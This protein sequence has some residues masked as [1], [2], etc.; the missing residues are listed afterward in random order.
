[1]RNSKRV[2][3]EKRM[4]I[5]I[6]VTDNRINIRMRFEKKKKIIWPTTDKLNVLKIKFEKTKH[7]S[8]SE[9]SKKLI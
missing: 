4:K 6:Q 5:F 3:I 7:I 1:M 9:L 2:I 8:V